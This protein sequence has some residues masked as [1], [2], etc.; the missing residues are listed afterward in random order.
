[1]NPRNLLLFLCSLIGLNC[2]P[3]FADDTEE[4][5]RYERMWPVLQQ[6]WYLDDIRDI[7]ISSQGY[8]YVVNREHNRI[9][10]LTLDGHLISHFGTFHDGFKPTQMAV[11]SEENFYVIYRH[12]HLTPKSYL[13]RKFNALGD[14]ISDKW[15]QKSQCVKDAF[16]DIAVDNQDHVYV[17]CEPTSGQPIVEKLSKDGTSLYEWFVKPLQNDESMG[18]T[19]ITINDNYVYV[20]ESHNHR[21]RKYTKYGELKNVWGGY[22]SEEGKFKYPQKIAIDSHGN[23]YVTDNDNNRIQKFNSEGEFIKAWSE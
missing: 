21:I 7:A 22:G 6:P 12:D 11:D 8:V 18:A 10:K 20:L 5:Y 15:G 17:T 16:H 9:E 14:L 2:L 23:I 1:M 3:L 4:I 13:I 19:K